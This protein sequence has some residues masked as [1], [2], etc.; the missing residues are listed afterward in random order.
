MFASS[1][2]TD[3]VQRIWFHMELLLK[4]VAR[5]LG[6][7]RTSLRQVR[8]AFMSVHSEPHRCYLRLHPNITFLYSFVR[9]DSPRV[10]ESCDEAFLV[11][12]PAR[13]IF[14]PIALFTEGPRDVTAI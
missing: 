10:E 12:Q 11:A 9:T 14:R 13:P 2:P 3:V 1:V 8:L 6:Q 5:R 7:F 4:L